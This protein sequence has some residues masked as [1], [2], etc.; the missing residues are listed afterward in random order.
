VS[1]NLNQRGELMNQIT[2][3]GVDLAKNVI[4]ACAADASGRTLYFRQF[5]F[6]GFAQWAA[7][8]PPCTVGMEACSS[9]HYWGRRLKEFG[10][11]PR[12]M[13]AEFV[14]P[15]RKSQAAKNDR[16]D[17]RAILSAVR[18]PDMRFVS[19][20]SVEQQTILAWHRV[21]AGL[22]L[23]RTALINRMRGLLAEFGVWL[24]RSA[25]TLV[26]ALPQL[27]E[28]ST[29]P[30]RLQPLLRQARER[31]RLLEEHIQLCD[32]QIRAH[33]KDSA[34]AACI[35]CL[36]GVGPLT[37]SA[38]VATIGNPLDFR[39]GRQL[40]AWAG[41][42]PRQ[43]SSGGKQRL[44]VISKRG[45]TYLRGLLTQG[46]RSTL[47]VALKRTADKRSRLQQW[48]VA[49]Y[50]RVGYHKTL[51]AIANKHARIIWAILVKGEQYDPEVWQRFKPPRAA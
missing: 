37:A 18:E 4:V 26:R 33:A 17:A 36:V 1:F 40:A 10:H 2:T 22:V 44:G 34:D 24:G 31:I 38:V 8:L 5:S 30:Q 29:L 20:K 7:N 21:R 9:A 51:V 3:V 27:A 12:L 43:R 48:I 16:N 14:E 42:V 13:A 25:G 46:A 15:F 45:D 39:N 41:L 23:E 6:H 35:S 11:T 28:Q 19:V 32:T 49:L 50:A 47:Q